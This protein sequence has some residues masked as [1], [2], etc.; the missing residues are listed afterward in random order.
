M[1]KGLAQLQAA[2]D[3]PADKTETTTPLT[4]TD[5]FEVLKK[6]E[7]QLNKQF[8]TTKSLVFLGNKVGQKMPSIRT[9]IPTLDLHVLGCGGIPRGRIIEVFGP[10]SSGKTT[11]TLHIIACEQQNTDNLVAFV[12]A[13]HA[14][15][16]SYA[17]K[18]G[19]NVDELL[20]S[21]PDS[22]EQALET[23]DALVDSGAV[24][25]IVVDSVAALVPQ[26]ELDGDMGDSHMG[27]QARMMSQAMRKLRGKAS[28]K[29]VTIIFINQ[30]RE[31]IG[32]MFGSPETTSGGR[33]LKFFSSVRLDIRR[34][35]LIKIGDEVVGHDMKVK[36]VK[37]KV[38]VPFHE[39]IVRLMYGIGI[40]TFQ[41]LMEFAVSKGVITQKG[42]WFN[43]GEEKLGQGLTNAID[44]IKSNQQLLAKINSD[45]EA[46][47]KQPEK[48]EKVL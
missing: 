11:I 47:I 2:L 16:P 38:G 23:V 33:A 26:A 48:D 41:D 46:I 25:L 24:S 19:V 45:I 9:N 17:A 12:D 1:S 27:L 43:Y 6:L 22:G 5:K 30:I 13:E 20:I 3:K 15:D 42:S 28:V 29:G 36:A 18:L 7:G 35:D 37:N 14:L 10:E 34:K 39:T 44:A 32:V 21:Q 8:D 4:K 31:K 40:D